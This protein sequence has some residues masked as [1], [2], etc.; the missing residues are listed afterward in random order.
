MWKAL[1]PGLGSG[2]IVVLQWLNHAWLFVTPWT[3]ALQAFLSFTI[4]QSWL[5]LMSIESVMPSK[6]SHPLFIPFYF[7]PQSFPVSGSFPVSQF[8]TS[9][10]QST[11]VSGSESVLPMNIQHWFPLGWTGWTPCSSQ[12]S[13]KSSPA[14]HFKSINSSVLRFRYGPTLTS[15]YD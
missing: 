7:C 13:Q 1:E 15:I 8:F 3:A 14:P 10:G 6:P 5:K 12:D 9:G 11:G 4:S 2:S